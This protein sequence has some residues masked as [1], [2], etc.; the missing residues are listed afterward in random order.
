MD[1]GIVIIGTDTGK[2]VLLNIKE[3]DYQIIKEY[4]IKI[5]KLGKLSKQKIIIKFDELYIYKYENKALE[6][7]KELKSSLNK[8]YLIQELIVINEKEIA[9]NYYQGGLFSSDYIGFFDLDKDIKIQTYKVSKSEQKSCLIN[10]NLFIFFDKY[11][12]YL[13]DLKN[14]CRKKTFILPNDDWIISILSLNDEKFLI[15]QTNYL[16]QFEVKGDNYELE[17]NCIINLRFFTIL[18]YINGTLLIK[19]EEELSLDEEDNNYYEISG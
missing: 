13:V 9:L 11:N 1:D 18:K 2:L 3:E 8:I 10:K 4:E 16:N 6:K 19:R 15:V 7:E 17:L 5:S 12:L 14:H